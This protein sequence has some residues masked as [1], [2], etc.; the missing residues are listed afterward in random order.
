MAYSTFVLVGAV[1]TPRGFFGSGSSGPQMNA[2]TLNCQR[3]EQ[4]VDQCSQSGAGNGTCEQR[5]VAGVICQGNHYNH[6]I[7]VLIWS[8][9]LFAHAFLLVLQ[10]EVLAQSVHT[11]RFV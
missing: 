6:S 5:D 9:M 8:V 4:T 10:P 11:V 3:S 2:G 7:S 1:I